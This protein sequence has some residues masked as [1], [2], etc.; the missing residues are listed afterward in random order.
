MS[1]SRIRSMRQQLINAIDKNFKPG[2]DKHS[3]KNEVGSNNTRIYSYSDRRNL[4]KFTSN[5]SNWIKE[6]HG[7]VRL[8]TQIKSEHVQEFLNL[9]AKTC[10]KATIEQYVSKSN[11]MQN[12]INATYNSHNKLNL[13]IPDTGK[14]IYRNKQMTLEHYKI[15]QKNMSGNGLKALECAKNFGLRVDE[16]SNLR[17]GDINLDKKIVRV[18][19]GKG[20]RDRDVYLKTKEQLGVAI[21]LYNSRLALTER[22]VPIKSDSINRALNR[23][24]QKIKLKDEYEKTGI[25]S[26]RKLYAQQEYDRCRNKGMSIEKARAVVSKQLGHSE[27]RGKDDNLIKRYIQNLH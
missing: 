6:N 15:L 25:H 23:A 16:I 12:L 22:V 10:S 18:I 5:F 8:A 20:G 9:K 19:N 13:T 24:M 4:V 27:E 26:I 2:M 11:K 14:D 21:K 17:K 1:R 3:I 7:E